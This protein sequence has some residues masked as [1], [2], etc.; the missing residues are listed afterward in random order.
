MGE[1]LLTKEA[2]THIHNTLLIQTD[3]SFATVGQNVLSN[4]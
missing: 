3:G 2:H 4:S 1:Q